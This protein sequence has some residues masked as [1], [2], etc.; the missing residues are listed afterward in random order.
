MYILAH[1]Y[2]LRRKR[3][4]IE[5]QGIQKEATESDLEEN[6]HLEEVGEIIWATRIEIRYCPFCGKRLPGLESVD[7][8]DYGRFEHLDFSRWC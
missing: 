6:S 4:G 3:R 8:A 5:P 7:Q 1:P 2:S